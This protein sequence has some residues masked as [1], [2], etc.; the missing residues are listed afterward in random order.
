MKDSRLPAPSDPAPVLGLSETTGCSSDGGWCLTPRPTCLL[1]TKCPTGGRAPVWYHECPREGFGLGASFACFPAAPVGWAPPD[2]PASVR[3]KGLSSPQT[4]QRVGV[5]DASPVGASRPA[6]AERSRLSRPGL[7][8]E[9][10]L[11]VLLGLSV[12]CSHPIPASRQGLCPLQRCQPQEHRLP[13]QDRGEVPGPAEK[14]VGASRAGTP[15]LLH[16]ALS[17]PGLFP[18]TGWSVSVPSRRSTGRAGQTAVTPRTSWA[19]RTQARS[20][21]SAAGV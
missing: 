1:R 15:P 6:W 3:Q 20:Q 12:W 4:P 17:I 13:P 11:P 9:R 10:R 2:T 18:P 7:S 14:T 21:V 16:P 5:A 8:G 19:P